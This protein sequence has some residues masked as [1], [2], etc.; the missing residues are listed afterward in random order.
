[1]EIQVG[2][3]GELRQVAWKYWD[4]AQVAGTPLKLSEREMIDRARDLMEEAVKLRMISD[5]PLGLFLSGGLD[6]S[7]ITA[8]AA[9]NSPG[10]VKTF[11][12]GFANSRF[13][14]EL[15][16][17]NLVA[18]KFRTEHHVLQADEACADSMTKV[19]RHFDEPF[20]NPTAILEYMIT[21]LM[22]KHVT[23]A[24]SGDGGDELFGGYVR[25][26]G[27]QLARRYRMLPQ[28]ITKGL[29]SRL[30]GFMNDA[31]AGR[32][33]FRRV[34]EFAQSA[35]QSEEDMYI[36]WV[37]YFSEREKQELYAPEFAAAVGDRNSGDFLRQFFRRGAQ[38]DP[39]SRLGYVDSASF[40][41]C[42]CLEYADRMSM[43]NSLEVRAPFTDYRLLEF[44]LQLP[45]K[46]KVRRTQ[47]KW[48]T[49]QALRDVLPAEILEKKKMGF[50]PPLPQW[51]NGEL[52]PVIAQLLSAK[53][54]ASRGIFQPQAVA[55]LVRDHEE[56][57]RDNA[58]KIWA[59]L[60]IEVWQR[61]YVDG[62]SEEAVLES[63][64]AGTQRKPVTATGA[65]NSKA[66]VICIR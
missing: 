13:Y 66:D 27:A 18:E 59:L 54:I 16:S 34:R 65:R 29:V 19:V 53:A 52:K 12:I 5:V 32:H 43:A 14:D 15:P 9:K 22:R 47:T 23:V 58:L 40:L 25:Y 3:E 42:N 45:D 49:R 26:A 17:A 51:I 36:D 35:W 61:M 44:A 8:F 60:M 2:A 30:A 6:S 64:L 31:T 7:A 4:A 20:G 55:K 37:G 33:G 57:R 11:T 46:M 48:I 24:I 41:C 63:A 21:R 28:F 1:M 39:L 10:Q 56:N 50:N 38:L 62:E